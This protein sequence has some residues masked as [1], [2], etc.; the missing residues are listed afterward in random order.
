MRL[1]RHKIVL[2]MAKL[3]KNKPCNAD[4]FEGKSHEHLAEV[5]VKHIKNDNYRGLI[6]IDGGW[7]SGKS[8]LVG[9]IESKLNKDITDDNK[10]H[11]FTY[12]AWAHQ[13]DLPR[14]TILE[15]MVEFL[16]LPNRPF[17]GSVKWHK[18]LDNL[19]AK[20][21][22]TS[23]KTVPS[24]G[25]GFIL[26]ILIAIVTPVSKL[27]CQ[28]L[29]Y[30]WGL[31]I[32]VFL[33]VI[34]VWFALSRHSK[35]MTEKYGQKPSCEQ[36]ITELFLIYADKV[37]EE[38]KHEVLI[39]REP[40]SRSFKRWI[41]EI[42]EELDANHLVIVIDNMDRLPKTKVQELWATIHSI[43]TDIELD[44]IRVIIPFDREHIKCAFQ[45]EDIQ[46]NAQ[47]DDCTKEDIIYGND[48]INK[49]FQIVFRVAPPILS[50]WK[51]FFN[52]MWHEA[53]GDEVDL[54][55][56]ILQIYDM[57][58]KEHSPR[59]IIAFI[60][61]FVTI[62]EIADHEIEDKYIALFI[63]GKE[64]ISGDPIKE[65]LE[66]SFLGSL[67]FIYKADNRMKQC[68]SSLY[69][70]LPVQN[71]MDVV[72]VRTVTQELDNNALQTLPQ[73]KGTPKFWTI[74]DHSIVSVTNIP[75]A[76]K[77]LDA[78]FNA[79]PLNSNINRTWS[80]L[81][82]KFVNQWTGISQYEDYHSV[83]LSHISQKNEMVRLLIKS[84]FM[85]LDSSANV[86]GYINGIDELEK[87]EGANV[88]QYLKN[89][90]KEIT[91][92][93]FVEFVT[94]KQENYCNYGLMCNSDELD[95]YLH[96]LE[97]DKYKDLSVIPYLLGGYE[98]PNYKQ[99]IKQS[100]SE[101][102]NDVNKV[103]YLI[104]RL[105]E[106][107]EAPIDINT[108]LPDSKLHTI[109]SNVSDTD[110]DFY[111]ELL[112]MIISRFSNYEYSSNSYS[113]VKLISSMDDERTIDIA[114][115]I[116]KYTTLGEILQQ[117]KSYTHNA[118]LRLIAK[119][120]LLNGKNQKLSIL[121]VLKNYAGIIENSDIQPSE[122]W[123][124][125]DSWH[126]QRNSIKVEHINQFPIKL[127][128]DIRTNESKVGSHLFDLA[129][130]Y[131]ASITQDMWK[132]SIAKKDFNYQLYVLDHQEQYQNLI[133]AVKFELKEYAKNTSYGPINKETIRELL[134][135]IASTGYNINPII[136]DVRNI[137]IQ[138]ST[139]DVK[140]F[141]Y[142][143]DILF[144]YGNLNN[145]QGALRGVVPTE[146]LGNREVLNIIM[147]NANAF[148]ELLFS[149]PEP[150][151]DEHIAKL[152][153][154]RNGEYA[155]DKP[156]TDFID[157]L[158]I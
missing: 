4:L 95:S 28:Y 106:I 49:T 155:H 63:F 127:Y 26:A 67:D 18:R 33:Y 56:A 9:M 136:Y 123:H 152:K 43:F 88:C 3:I 124:C 44:N 73:L 47:N 133:D 77:A 135:I 86:K 121:S 145:K 74:L 137:F 52:Q 7:G 83:L 115:K 110:S 22:E 1:K 131:M 90:H 91:P 8:N 97:L 149:T 69:Y 78:L 65:I 157:S 66:P 42:S 144:Q 147:N 146:I 82:N 29:T 6:G 62:K 12:D 15:E 54:D 25:A 132:Q 92:E 140:K 36:Y 10:Y 111:N 39:E 130:Q 154:L 94:D 31:V 16:T 59:K 41:S 87:V 51:G 134:D 38:T 32:S 75:N 72:F 11:F 89:V 113:Y 20:K 24:L 19:L 93:K 138:S 48:F 142:F 141:V 17:D 57:L 101:N 150:E 120:L 112:A 103:M 5:I 143:G 2:F 104:K 119:E 60:N 153:A 50:G 128:D 81:Y 64:K 126:E 68:L 109:I 116:Q 23:T 58:T 85:H 102:S 40:T 118:T 84:Y 107:E 14:R 156:I 151:R 108:Y 70:Q 13:N 114:S 158:G 34:A 105:H 71:A 45:S 35:K 96:A 122:F 53:F 117:L 100:I 148:R 37:N 76:V 61:E 125:L 46:V 80:S 139:I 129:N 21:K 98:L 27:L 99:R 79:D 55:G 30:P